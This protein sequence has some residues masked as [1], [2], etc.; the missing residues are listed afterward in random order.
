M[1]NCSCCGTDVTSP[2]FYNG[3]VYG[4]TC[5]KKVN[6]NAKRNKPK[7]KCFEV[8]VLKV[9][10]ESENS[11]RGQALISINGIRSAATAYRSYMDGVIGNFIEIGNFKFHD[12]KWWAFV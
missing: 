3:G 5:I 6:P 12:G 1:F 10:F 9:K 8:E 4:W 7:S 11:T 2:Y